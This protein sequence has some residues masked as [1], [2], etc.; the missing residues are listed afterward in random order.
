MVLPGKHYPTLN[1]IDRA[2]GGSAMPTVLVLSSSA[3]GEASVSNE[4]V[5]DAVARLRAR[6]PA[7][8]VITRDLG[9]SPI[10]HLVLDS[11]LA[12]RGAEPGN[13]LQAAARALSDELVDELK[14]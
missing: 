11:A 1:A 2:L 4:L 8:K 13:P 9:Q 10:P 6:D 5:R 14:A 3:L 7:L 12:V